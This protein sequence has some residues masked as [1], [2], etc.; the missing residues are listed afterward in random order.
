MKYWFGLGLAA[1]LLW[2]AALP[3]S[4]QADTVQVGIVVQAQGK[5]ST[6][7]VSLPADKATGLDALRA[8]QLDLNVVAGALGSAVCRLD[9]VGCSYPADTCFCQCQGARCSYWAYY[10][11]MP[12][13]KWQYS[14]IGAG[15]LPLANHSV[16][17]WLWTE[18]QDTTPVGNLPAVTFDSICAAGIKTAPTNTD[19]PTSPATLL[20]YGVLGVAVISLGGI[21]L[22]RRRRHA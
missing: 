12:D 1:L 22:W 4:A 11:L 7:C 8:T 13:G 10:H 18:A 14:Q 17:G 2:W 15:S 16:E 19:S 6:Y 21:A 5:V 20:G 3:V 9:K